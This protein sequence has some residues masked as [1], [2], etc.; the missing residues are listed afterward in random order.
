MDMDIN[1]MK[2]FIDLVNSDAFWSVIFWTMSAG[3]GVAGAVWSALNGLRKVKQTKILAESAKNKA[4]IIQEQ[5]TLVKKDTYEA[6]TE[7]KVLS[8][9]I[10]RYEKDYFRLENLVNQLIISRNIDAESIEHLKKRIDELSS[11]NNL[12]NVENLELNKHNKEL[13]N[14]NNDLILRINNL[15]D[16]LKLEENVEGGVNEITNIS[17]N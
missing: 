16:R 15:L 1:I 7:T 12:L 6:Y 2:I 8:E 3:S 17:S 11:L 14:R 5:L 9:S 4:D 13:V 10:A